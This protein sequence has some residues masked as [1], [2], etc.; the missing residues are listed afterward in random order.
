MSSRGIVGGSL[1]RGQRMRK[2]YTITQIWVFKAES[3]EDALEEVRD[4]IVNEPHDALMGAS[5]EL[6]FPG[7]EEE[8]EMLG[9]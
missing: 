6:T 2:R 9:A 3:A 7:D 8:D 1:E 5:V 4:S